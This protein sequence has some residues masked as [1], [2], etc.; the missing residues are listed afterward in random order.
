MQSFERGER[1]RRRNRTFE[2]RSAWP[3]GE[4]D[5]L[6]RRIKE[7]VR[8]LG[9]V[10]EYHLLGLAYELRDCPPE[11]RKLIIEYSPRGP[12]VITPEENINRRNKAENELIAYY[13][14]QFG[15]NDGVTMLERLNNA[16]KMLEKHIDIA[17]HDT[18]PKPTH[19]NRSTQKVIA[20]KYKMA[21]TN[22]NIEEVLFNSDTLS[23]VISY[24]P[25]TDLLNLALTCK[26]FGVSNTDEQSLIED[27]ARIAIKVLA[28]EEELATLP[29]YN[30][31]SSLAD[32]HHLQFMRGPLTFDQLV[33]AEYVNSGDKSCIRHSIRGSS[34]ET[35]ISNNILRAGKHYAIFEC[36]NAYN[37]AFIGVMRPGQANQDANN[38]PIYENFYRHFSPSAEYNNNND[39]AQCCM[40]GTYSKSCHSSAW[41]GGSDFIKEAWDGMEQMFSSDELGM[42]LDLDE[43]TLTVYKNGRKLG[44][45]K[46][47]LVGPYCW[48]VSIGIRTSV[49]TIKRGK[50]PSR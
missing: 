7:L 13:T 32:Y 42:L 36:D 29:Y 14:Y 22:N 17:A 3:D 18:L 30:G 33:G 2:K 37:G 12:K 43:G 28:T 44:I 41:S 20:K 35:A 10:S 8:N 11:L 1:R 5:I 9:E 15:S 40:Y 47:G 21:T 48:V 31:E 6:E 23:K 38:V 16:V 27:S 39:D 19:Y 24:L 46:R 34:W 45:M 4:D 26:R 49:T 50:I 25:S